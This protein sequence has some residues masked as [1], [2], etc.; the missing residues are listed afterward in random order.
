[1]FRYVRTFAPFYIPIAFFLSLTAIVGPYSTV[2][3]P[4][5][6]MDMLMKDGTLRSMLSLIGSMLAAN[7]LR[8]VL[9][10]LF[11]ERY[12]PCKQLEIEKGVN[13]LLMDKSR[14]IS[15]KQY[16]DPRFRDIY[17]RAVTHA[18]KGIK[19][20]LDALTNL[21]DRF[22]YLV[23]V[24]T[25]MTSLDPYLIGFSL[26][27]V[28]VLFFFQAKISSY[29]YRTDVMITGDKRRG[30][31]A[32]KLCYGADYVSD[33]KLL[34]LSN[35]FQEEYLTAGS[36]RQETLRKRS[37]RKSLLR[38]SDEGLRLL[39]LNVATMVYLVFRIRAG[40]L[41]VSS[42]IVLITATMQL[43]YELF[44]FVKSLNSFYSL[45]IYTEDLVKVLEWESEVETSRDR[46]AID[47]VDSVSLKKV[48]F[49]Y[50]GQEHLVLQDITMELRK[51]QR[52]AVVGHNG[53][54]KTTLARLL[55]RLYT[56]EIG[57]I[58]VNCKDISTIDINSWRNQIGVVFQDYRAYAMTIAE[59]VL[60][61]RVQDS[62]DR[63]IVQKALKKADLWDYVSSLPEKEDTIL[64]REFDDTGIRLSGG[65]SQKLSLA[66]VFAQ[67]EK[68]VIIMDEVSAAIDPYSE[69]R[70]NHSI[71]DFCQDKIF[72]FISHRLSL[73]KEMDRIY[74]FENGS[75]TEAGTHMELLT[76]NGN[77]AKMYHLQAKAYDFNG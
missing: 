74:Y 27:C 21:A 23:S 32:K 25:I 46:E 64:T 14:V 20:F 45:S 69:A 4:K 62:A 38:I 5:L 63:L 37:R 36:R 10:T 1:M 77:Y 61:R 41:E 49:S 8:L 13:V 48:S 58:A 12:K 34:R 51:G 39:I 19:S 43:S 28:F 22:L 47:R 75:I 31:Y 68:Q 18:N 9:L 56:V 6:I 40:R 76:Q 52:I 54:G 35:F 42:F 70:I 26:C 60:M 65:Q 73:M 17:D 2:L 24:V 33:V 57:E 7:L 29:S 15:M 30:E 55:M 67:S 16:D 71:L 72:I 53:A 11:E 50:P 66:R 3:V 59:N 44:G